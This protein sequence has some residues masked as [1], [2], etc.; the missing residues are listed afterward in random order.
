MKILGGCSRRCQVL[1][2]KELK[3]ALTVKLGLHN[4]GLVL[5]PAE[6]FFRALG[7][8]GQLR[9]HRPA[10]LHILHTPS[11]PVSVCMSYCCT[12][13]APLGGKG[14]FDR[15]PR[16]DHALCCNGMTEVVVSH[17]VS[18]QQ[19]KLQ[20]RAQVY[21]SACPG[22]V[23]DRAD[24]TSLQCQ[25]MGLCFGRPSAQVS[26]LHVGMLAAEAVCVP[27][28]ACACCGPSALCRLWPGPWSHCTGLQRQGGSPSV[29]SCRSY[30]SGSYSNSSAVN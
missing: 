5:H 11:S 6:G 18:A 20:S 15:A 3:A 17:L 1:P 9:A 24:A 25:G 26:T 29:C 13:S 12:S 28:E 10:R 27:G 21:Q 30:Q 14:C 2:G 19:M 7:S 22:T 23:Q 8:A 4:K 16:M